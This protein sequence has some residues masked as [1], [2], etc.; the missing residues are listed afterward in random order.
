MHFQKSII[1]VYVYVAYE[2]VSLWKTNFHAIMDISFY[3]RF[4]L[5]ISFSEKD[6]RRTWNQKIL[7]DI[8][9]LY[10]H[11]GSNLMKE[12]E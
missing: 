3:V 8:D 9:I 4:F 2:N 7:H 12:K 10:S 11:L 5:A 6:Q 1:C